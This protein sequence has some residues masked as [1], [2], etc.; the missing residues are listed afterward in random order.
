MDKSIGSASTNR[1]KNVIAGVFVCRHSMYC[2]L[3]WQFDSINTCGEIW[4]LTV[5]F[6]AITLHELLHVAHSIIQFY[7]NYVHVDIYTVVRV[8]WC[9]MR[10][11][12]LVRHSACRETRGTI[13]Y[14]STSSVLFSMKLN[15][16][17]M[18]RTYTCNLLILV[19]FFQDDS[20]INVYVDHSHTCILKI[21]IW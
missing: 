12:Y 10:K 11:Y 5:A 16:P 8:W 21:L 9:E 15:L 18:Y 4:D 2:M 20:L 13:F 3:L 17:Y 14:L 7:V 1:R 19:L 6:A